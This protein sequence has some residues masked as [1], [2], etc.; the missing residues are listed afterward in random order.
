MTKS[1]QFERFRVSCFDDSFGAWRDGLDVEAARSLS[2][3]ERAEAEALVLSSLPQT[4][5]SRPFIASGVMRIGAASPILQERLCS[6]FSSRH[7]YLRVHA[8]HALYLIE[9]WSDAATTI[10][11]VLKD[12]PKTLDRQWTRM[13]A[14][15]ALGDFVDDSRCHA[16]LFAAVEDEDDFIGFLAIRSLQKIFSRSAAISVLLETL[17]DSQVEPHRWKPE[18]LRERQRAFLELES[19]TGIPM[20]AVAIERK[21]EAQQDAA[22]NS[23]P[24]SQLPLLPDVQASESQRTPP[25]G[26]CG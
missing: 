12:T 15:E 7:E 6:G 13:M 9:K 11:D 18:F 21:T 4:N 22:P 14:V 1:R 20:P 16:A 10:I 19:E 5:D 8:A 3:S 23:R 2:G 25:A 17:R 24:P 26:G